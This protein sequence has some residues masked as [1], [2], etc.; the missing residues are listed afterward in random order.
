MYLDQ[1]SGAHTV[2]S[3]IVEPTL[4]ES[5]TIFHCVINRL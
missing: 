1:L 2:E 5:D 3:L 4:P